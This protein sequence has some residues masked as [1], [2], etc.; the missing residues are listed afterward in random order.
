[1]ASV[2]TK[3]IFD[4][5]GDII[6]E[7][8]VRFYGL[9]KKSAFSLNTLPFKDIAGAGSEI[10]LHAMDSTVAQNRRVSIVIRHPKPHGGWLDVGSWKRWWS[11][12]G[13]DQDLGGGSG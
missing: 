2:L 7:S 11:G 13:A 1:M 6:P 10:C 4:L 3:P 12:P 9:R 8:G 5:D